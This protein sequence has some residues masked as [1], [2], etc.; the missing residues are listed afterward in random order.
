MRLVVTQKWVTK[1]FSVGHKSL[2]ENISY[3]YQLKRDEQLNEVP[4][5]LRSYL[6]VQPEELKDI[7][8]Q[9]MQVACSYSV[10]YLPRYI[11]RLFSFSASWE[12]STSETWKKPLWSCLKRPGE[13]LVAPDPLVEDPCYG[14]L[15]AATP[16]L[17]LYTVKCFTKQK[18]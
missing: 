18:K 14:G 13:L 6:A 1:P 2:P 3:M 11:C 7:S 15:W 4:F 12:Q 10:L 9:I 16:E 17:L 8:K 5:H